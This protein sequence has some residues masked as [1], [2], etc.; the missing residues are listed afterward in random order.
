M[1]S[2][3][4]KVSAQTDIIQRGYSAGRKILAELVALQEHDW[5]W[6]KPPPQTLLDG[7][8]LERFAET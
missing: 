7:L 2:A 1:A 3:T 5:L 6:P 4:K 8:T